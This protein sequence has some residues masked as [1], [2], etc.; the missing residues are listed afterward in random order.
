MRFLD[1]IHVQNLDPYYH[2]ERSSTQ[3]DQEKARKE[4]EMSK[5]Y[6]KPRLIVHPC[7]QN[8]TTDEAIESL[9]DKDPG[10][11]IIRP[12]SRG[13]SFLTLTLKL[14]DGVYAHKAIVEGGKEHKDITS[15]FRI[16]KT[17][18]IGEDTFEDL[19]EVMDRYVDPLVS[20]LKAMLSYRKFRK[21]TKVEVDQL[22]SIEKSE[23]RMYEDIDSLVVYFQK[24]IDDR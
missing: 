4:R 6:F 21:G 5:K 12:S 23:K 15:L 11:S 19:D 13:P 7:F 8:I 1:L 9:S 18:K 2:E 3:S 10:E 16:G 17:L 24:H 14:Y 22:L 20:H